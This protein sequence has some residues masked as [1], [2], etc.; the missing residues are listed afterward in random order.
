[1]QDKVVIITGA[2]GGLGGA[3]ARQFAQAGARL[4]LSD[5]HEALAAPLA[6]D[7]G[8]HFIAADVTQEAA[9]AALVD[10]AVA[11]FGR[12]DVMINNAGQVGA[13]GPIAQTDGDG[14]SRTL[15]VLLDSVFFGMKHAARVMIPQGAGGAI[16]S[17]ASVAGI[18]P[19]G[20][21]AYTAAKHGVV[22]LTLSVASELAPHRIRVNAVAPGTVPT[23]M[24]AAVY[25]SE[26]KMR[27]ATVARNPLGRVVEADEIAAAFL[28]L[29]GA[30]G[31]NITGQVLTIDAGLSGC[32]LPASYYARTPAYIGTAT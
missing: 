8:G 28:Y 9:V 17:T 16:L 4:M 1:M 15:A 12:V 29:A 21:H 20:P 5:L 24:T 3:I 25:G 19:L 14:W 22:G 13:V 18:A 30:S 31:R 2:G 6:R 26:A 23:G 7:L 11:A 27:A 10:G 32:P